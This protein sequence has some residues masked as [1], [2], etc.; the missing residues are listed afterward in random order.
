V[1][2]ISNSTI[3]KQINVYFIILTVTSTLP[4]KI[5]AMQFGQNQ[6]KF[7]T[8]AGTKDFFPAPHLTLSLP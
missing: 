4:L 8:Q 5:R 7:K 2:N 3:N 6:K 1:A